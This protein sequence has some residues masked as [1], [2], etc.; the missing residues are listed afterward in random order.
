MNP[1]FDS[2][3]V[4][5]EIV[6]AGILSEKDAFWFGDVALRTDGGNT[7]MTVVAGDQAA[8]HGILRRIHDLHIPL[9]S[10]ACLDGNNP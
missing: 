8:L 9:L 1:P 7:V 2:R 10:A 4:R 3:S 5:Y 6:V